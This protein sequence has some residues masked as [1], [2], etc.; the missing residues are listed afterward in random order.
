IKVTT[1][2]YTLKAV[3]GGTSLTLTH[4]GLSDDEKP[5]Y[6]DEWGR[7]LKNLVSA[8]TTGADTRITERILI[9]IFPD[10]MDEKAAKRLGLPVNE[11]LLVANTIPNLGAEKAG[12]KAGDLVVEANGKPV[13]NNAPLVG[14]LTGLKPGDSAE[15]KFYRGAE[16]HTVTLTLSGYPLP[17]MAHN[18]IELADRAEKDYMT[19]HAE[20]SDIVANLSDET[21]NTPPA[22]DEW[23]VNQVLAHLILTERNTQEF[24]GGYVQ[25]PELHTFTGNAKARV[26]AVVN[27]YKNTQGLLNELKRAYA[28][29][30][31]IVRAFE[32][33]KFDRPYILWWANFQMGDITGGH[34]RTHINQIKDTLAK[35]TK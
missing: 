15:V 24:L 8:L 19:L 3:D 18:F 10:N 14:N 28:E 34:N 25:A 7:A 27:T 13:G 23:S 30:V 35:V 6:E 31:A 9:G 29:C 16:K 33:E 32:D 21:T 11:G 17:P 5:A 4:D 22:E 2:T 12:L 1:V 26:N 20:L